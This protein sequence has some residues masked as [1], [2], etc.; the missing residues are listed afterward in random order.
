MSDQNPKRPRDLFA[1]IAARRQAVRSAA[2][3]SPQP[4]PL[5]EC[6]LPLRKTDSAMV[7]TPQ[8][9][10]QTP[11]QLRA[12][13]LRQREKYAP[14]LRNLAPLMP[15][16]QPRAGKTCISARVIGLWLATRY[17][18]YEKKGEKRR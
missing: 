5:P 14:F 16:T 3:V 17:E 9:K 18:W 1:E 10:M 11:E 2:L 8:A 15:A 4:A 7:F 6:T 12:E 13:L